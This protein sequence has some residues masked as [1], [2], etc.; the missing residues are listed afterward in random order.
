MVFFISPAVTVTEPSRS[1]LLPRNSSAVR[2][3]VASPCPLAGETVSHSWPEVAVQSAVVVMATSAVPSLPV[4]DT[5]AGVTVRVT[6]GFGSG[7]TGSGCWQA[8]GSRRA[9]RAA[10][11]GE[12]L[13]IMLLRIV[14]SDCVTVKSA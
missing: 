4:R 11:K 2:V 3:I 6:S 8:G 1:R 7:L 5:E 14:Y 12:R 13:R 9:T 10:I